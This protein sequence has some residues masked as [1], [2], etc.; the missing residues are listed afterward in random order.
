[1]PNGDNKAQHAFR[2]GGPH[3]MDPT[4]LPQN[5]PQND[6]KMDPTMDPKIRSF[7]MCLTLVRFATFSSKMLIFRCVFDDFIFAIFVTPTRVLKK[8]RFLEG[9]AR[10]RPDGS[11]VGKWRSSKHAH[12]S[13]EIVFFTIGCL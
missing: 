10:F 5:R 12:L 11:E 9:F 4:K 7:A 1:M 13:S 3:K 2:R 8:C 6:P